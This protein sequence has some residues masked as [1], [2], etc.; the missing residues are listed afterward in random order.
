MEP[1]TR[2]SGTAAQKE[3]QEK[4]STTREG[5]SRSY[6][7]R[8]HPIGGQMSDIVRGLFLRTRLPW[9]LEHH[10]R[11]P[12][13]AL[14]SFVNGCISIGIMA[15]LAVVTHSPFIFPSLGPTAFLF[16]YTPTAPAASPRNTVIGHAIGAAAGY[17]SLVVTGLTMAG[18]AL[19]VGV[20]WP[21][22]IAAGLSLGLTAGLMVLLKSP[23]P[24][25]GTT[26]TVLSPR[27]PRQPS[28]PVLF[29]LARVLRR[30]Q[31]L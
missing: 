6:I 28:Q 31:A 9:L 1:E 30:L 27:T 10:A 16:F 24:P 26:P 19:T 17:L 8:E 3:E 20:T 23:H 25:A 12:V 11:I 29:L 22:V 5:V 18:P 14:F 21:R 13:L 7:D 2:S 4:P 15:A